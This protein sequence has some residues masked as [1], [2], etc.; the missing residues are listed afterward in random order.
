[1]DQTMKK[2]DAL[3]NMIDAC[4]VTLDELAQY[5]SQRNQPEGDSNKIN[6]NNNNHSSWFSRIWVELTDSLP[7][8]AQTAFE[9]AKKAKPALADVPLKR[10]WQDFI[11]FNKLKKRQGSIRL[12]A[13]LGFLK[14]WENRLDA[15]E[16]AKPH[17]APTPALTPLQQRFQKLCAYAKSSEGHTYRRQLEQLWGSQ[18]YKQKIQEIALK[19]DVS[20]YRAAFALHGQAVR[21]GIIRC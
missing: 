4:G 17:V 9:E 10:L 15:P 12:S 13:F 16:P 2:L 11:A 18:T 19:W 8:P 5:N 6:N 20:P 3:L 21:D 1:M 7:E 14:V